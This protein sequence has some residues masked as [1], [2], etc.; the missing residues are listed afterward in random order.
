MQYFIW[1]EF[2][3]KLSLHF[4]IGFNTTNNYNSYFVKL[5][6]NCELSVLTTKTKLFRVEDK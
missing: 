3:Q 2:L 6:K 5:F 1:F 4:H